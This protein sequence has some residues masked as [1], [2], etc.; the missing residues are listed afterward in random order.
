MKESWSNTLLNRCTRMDRRWNKSRLLLVSRLLSDLFARRLKK[1]Q[2]NSLIGPGISTAIDSKWK[3]AVRAV[4]LFV[5]LTAACS[6]TDIGSRAA[7][8]IYEWARGQTTLT[9]QT[10]DF[11]LYA[12]G[13]KWAHQGVFRL[14]DINP[15]VPSCLLLSSLLLLLSPSSSSSFKW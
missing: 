14:T 11:P 7:Q 2:A 1:S 12:T 6:A 15:A 10:K 3:S 9:S 5:F 4:Y 8:A 13:P